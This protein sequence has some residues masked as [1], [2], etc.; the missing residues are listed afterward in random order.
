MSSVPPTSGSSSSN[1]SSS[2]TSGDP[3]GDVNLSDFMQLMIAQ[4]QNQDPTDPVSNSDLMQQISDMETIQ[5]NVQLNS[6]LTGLSLND[7]L[8]AA[9]VMINQYVVGTDSTG[10][11][12]SGTVES[13]SLVDGAASLN[14][15]S[16]QV[17]LANVSEIIPASEAPTE[18]TE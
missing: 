2:S 6:T 3:F 18:S 14:I 10:A 8:T 4:L 1:S 5:S 16:Q 7:S 9:S 15:G 12:A 17:P 13:V 11:S